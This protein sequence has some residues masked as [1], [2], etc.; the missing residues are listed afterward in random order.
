MD[1]TPR[2]KGGD[3]ILTLLVFGVDLWAE[4]CCL[5]MDSSWK[6][7]VQDC[8]GYDFPVKDQFSRCSI[9]A[10]VS[11]ALDFSQL[12]WSYCSLLFV[13][14]ILFLDGTGRLITSDQFWN[15]T[16]KR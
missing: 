2:L 8:F 11:A 5:A 3:S 15:K 9:P 6:C 7:P 10:A 16:Q 1:R 14:A 13:S 4:G 12:R